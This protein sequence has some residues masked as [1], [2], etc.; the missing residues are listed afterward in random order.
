MTPHARTDAGHVATYLRQHL[1]AATGGL[2]LARRIAGKYAQ[3]SGGPALAGVAD[4]IAEDR[5]ALAR[6][7]EALD[8]RPPRVA[9]AVSWT[10][11]HLSRV[12]MDAPL[13]ARS[14]LTPV[15]ELEALVTGISAKAAGWRSLQS[16]SAELGLDDAALAELV[17]R[18]DEQI[19]VVDGLRRAAFRRFATR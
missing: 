12:P 10:A 6:I 11:E 1:A 19:A 5:Q 3:T 7:A 4:A 13:A 16:A 14:P 15:L 9:S 2:S 18:A 17:R 8:V